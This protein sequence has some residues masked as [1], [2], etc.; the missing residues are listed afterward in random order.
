MKII[1][2][3]G[4]LQLPL[5]NEEAELYDKFDSDTMVN[6]KELN[7]R[8]LVVANNL[9][10]KNVLIRKNNDGQITYSRSKYN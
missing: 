6:R 8:E 2:I 5:T 3:M 9:V 10:N 1:E 7:E 4:S